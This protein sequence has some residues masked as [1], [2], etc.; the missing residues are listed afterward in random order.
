M[1]PPLAV[2]EAAQRARAIA[3]PFEELVEATHA[4]EVERQRRLRECREQLDGLEKELAAL[5][6]A[7]P[8]DG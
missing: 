3:R 8:G 6:K 4:T 2:Q 1:P 7:E 5:V